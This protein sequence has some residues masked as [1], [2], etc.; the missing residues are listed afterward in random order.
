MKYFT[1]GIICIV[2]GLFISSFKDAE[3]KSLDSVEIQ[4]GKL[5]A[6]TD[7]MTSLKEEQERQAPVCGDVKTYKTF[8]KCYHE[9]CDRNNVWGKRC[10]CNECTNKCGG[11][12]VKCTSTRGSKSN[13]WCQENCRKTVCPECESI[14]RMYCICEAFHWGADEH[15]D[16]STSRSIDPGNLVSSLYGHEFAHVYG[17]EELTNNYLLKINN[18]QEFYFRA[19]LLKCVLV[20]NESSVIMMNVIWQ[21]HTEYNSTDM[22]D[23]QN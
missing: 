21:I 1:L 19:V 8:G 6:I 5:R 10:D 9:N 12:K 11:C 2:L 17:L 3:M 13:E 23:F 16:F 20:R 22:K 4:D 18:Q 14:C 7:P 15:L